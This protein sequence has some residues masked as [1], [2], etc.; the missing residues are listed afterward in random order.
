MQLS[1]RLSKHVYQTPHN[2]LYFYLCRKVHTPSEV[3]LWSNSASTVLV[4]FSKEKH[5]CLVL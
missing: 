2:R 4:Q 5:L 3:T 1:W